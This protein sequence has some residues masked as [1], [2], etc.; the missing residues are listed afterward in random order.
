ML[1]LNLFQCSNSRVP[2]KIVT[3][4]KFIQLCLYFYPILFFQIIPQSSINALL[5]Y[6]INQNEG[7]VDSN[8]KK[9]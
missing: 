1:A 8:F 7:Y 6:G 2:K 5:A 3:L 4:L 9:K